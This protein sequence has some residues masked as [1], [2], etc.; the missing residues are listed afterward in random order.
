MWLEAWTI[1]CCIISDQQPAK[2]L[3]LWGYQL[4]V[5]QAAKRSRWA[6]VAEYDVQFRQRASCCS[7]VQ[8]DKIDMDL[9]TRCFTGQSLSFCSACNKYGHVAAS[10]L[11]TPR[12]QA[13]NSAGSTTHTCDAFNKG[14]YS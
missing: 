11:S 7:E 4:Q 13:Q 5:L 8:W 12:T 2:S 10:C 6:A 1:Y 14:M 9:Y 3:E